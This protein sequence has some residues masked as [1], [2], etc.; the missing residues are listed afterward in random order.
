MNN[1]LNKYTSEDPPFRNGIY[2]D[3][4]AKYLYSVVREYKPK[5]IIDFAPR[6]GKTTSCIIS[7]IIK[8]LQESTH[9]IKYYVFEKD[10]PF[11]IEIKTYLNKIILENN[12][13]NIVEIFYNDNIIDSKILDEIN[14]VDLLFIDAN[15]DYILAKWYVETLFKK[16]KIGGII[17]MHDIHYN[18]KNNGW[19]DVRMSA[20]RAQHTHPDYT[21]INTMRELYPTIFEKY[22]DGQTYVMKYE[23][24]I[25]EEFYLKNQNNVEMY[26]TLQI[27]KD[28]NLFNGITNFNVL[29]NC[30][31]YFIIKKQI[32]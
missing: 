15:H 18:N 11:L 6:E 8:N 23:S 9:K 7:G 22:F 25:I 26:S 10:I 32:S 27:S 12:L 20:D 17:H 31:M 29:S 21:D 1:L 16:V 19:S 28:N 5:T 14:D 2:S 4:D 24:D 13:E 30:S 3:F